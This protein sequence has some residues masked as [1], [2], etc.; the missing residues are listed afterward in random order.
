VGS[1]VAVWW[2]R[3]SS[4]VQQTVVPEGTVTSFGVKAKLVMLIVVAPALQPPLGAEEAWP[5]EGRTTSRTRSASENPLPMWIGSYNLRF[6]I[7][8]LP[9]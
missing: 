2:V 6:S 7:K 5:A 4:F 1:E 3:P 8:Y 9:R